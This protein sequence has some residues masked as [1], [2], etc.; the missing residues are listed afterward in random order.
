VIVLVHRDN[1]VLLGRSSRFPNA[2]YSVLAG[3]VEPG[4]SLEETVAR[5][6]YEETAIRVQDITYFGS[7]PWP[8]P[9]SLM[10]GFTA[11]YA[12]GDIKLLDDE[13]QDAGWFS[14]DYLPVI[15]GS[16]SIARKLIDWWVG[17][18]TTDSAVSSR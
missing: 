18:Q 1:E 15:P 3:F 10:I 9:N 6:V 12:G 4:E 7:Q 16:I 13:I 2:F 14:V 11:T 17:Q 8:F 5:E